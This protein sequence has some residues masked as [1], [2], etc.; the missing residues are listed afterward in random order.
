MAIHTENLTRDFGTLRALDNLTMDVPSGVVF[1]FLGP[2]GSGKTTTIRLLLGLIQPT[3]GSASVLGHDVVGEADSIRSMTG[4]LLEYTGLYERMTAEDNLEYFGRIARMTRN[5][6]KAR[7][8]ELLSQI[9]L[10]DRR[11][12][13]VGKWSRGMKQ[14]LAVARVIFHRPPLVF[15]DEPTAGLDPVA[16]ASLREDLSRLVR[17]EGTTVFLTTHN[18]TEAEK[19]CE[20][21]AVVRN[22]VLLAIGHPDELRRRAARSNTLSF[23]GRSFPEAVG[24]LL[25]AR[26]EVLGV[27]LVDGRLDVSV[28]PGTDV[29]PLVSL[30]IGAGALVEEVF[31]PKA[32]L[33]ELFLD[34][35]EDK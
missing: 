11:M 22:G 21:V 3:S 32:S 14:K 35:V 24:P 5:D 20:R 4:A 6:R 17:R 15:L 26:P 13:P 34:L 19:L 9:G 18:L 23:V 25:A 16:A 33:E 29:A 8:R 1:G 7:A 2:N 10:W 31:K 30:A 27:E 12:D 28:R